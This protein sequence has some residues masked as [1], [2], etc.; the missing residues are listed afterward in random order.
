MTAAAN[1]QGSHR[2]PGSR[3]SAWLAVASVY[4]GAAMQGL[5][6]VSFA[7]SGPTLRMAQHL[8]DA[9]YGLVF[10]P[11]V[12][13]TIVG[14]L[15]GSTVAQRL[16]MQ[17][18]LWIALLFDALSQLGLASVESVPVPLALPML[19]AAATA[20]GLGFGFMGSPMNG[21]PALFF[22][23]RTGAATV[24]I[25]CFNGSG[26]IFGPMLLQFTLAH[27]GFNAYPLAQGMLA[28]ALVA[29]TLVARFDPGARDDAA[30]RHAE[31][32]P[33]RSAAFWLLAIIAVTYSFAEGTF[34]NWASVY[35]QED[36]HLPADVA[37][38]GLSAFWAGVVGGRLLVS[39]LILKLPERAVWRFLP[40]VMA[41][42]FL[43]L[44]SVDSAA[45][46]IGLFA[47]A[48]LGCSAFFP[49][50]VALTTRRFPRHLAFAS[51]MMIAALM[52]G[53]GLGSFMLGALRAHLSFEALYRASVLYP[54]LALLLTFVVPKPETPAG[55]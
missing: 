4:L 20:M 44:P 35:L 23:T 2:D 38:L 46:G 24:G 21:C 3:P 19:L 53:N 32:A 34:G 29:L 33:W 8:S 55:R 15:L 28:L 9:Q 51:A 27:A 18:L 48:G 6:L 50:T 26:L 45:T 40:L 37:A 47:L 5:A 36:R 49:L 30:A 42:A 14:A 22:P 11:Q 10:L 41:A 31:T 17:R 13:A 16:G 7:A 54:A 12:G 52:A 43:L 1:V 25:H 39:L